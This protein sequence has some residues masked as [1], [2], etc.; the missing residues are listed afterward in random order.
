MERWRD[1]TLDD[2]S[3]WPTEGRVALPPAHVDDRGYIQSLVNFPMKNLSLIT[4]RKGS[5]RSNHYHV[6]DWHYMY[7]L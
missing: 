2:S 5:V 3:M 4:S 6:T 7:V 1:V